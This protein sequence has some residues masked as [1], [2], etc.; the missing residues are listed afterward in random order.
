MRRFQNFFW[1]QSQS[2]KC[3]MEAGLQ[4]WCRCSKRSSHGTCAV[5]VLLDVS[6]VSR[7]QC[8]K[9][10]LLAWT[11]LPKRVAKASCSTE[12]NQTAFLDSENSISLVNKY[13]PLLLCSWK[14]CTGFYRDSL[15]NYNFQKFKCSTQCLTHFCSLFSARFRFVCNKII[16]HKMFDHIVLVIIFLNCITIAMERPRIDPGSA[17]SLGS[18]FCSTSGFF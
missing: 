1:N 2:K 10:R 13:K 15:L 18:Q 14:H 8:W 9:K 12:T 6:I 11:H 3:F 5:C 4:D 7:E 17:V 16:T